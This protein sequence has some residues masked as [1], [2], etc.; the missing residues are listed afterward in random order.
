MCSSVFVLITVSVE[1]DM[2]GCIN[3]KLYADTTILKGAVTHRSEQDFRGQILSIF[4]NFRSKFE[5]ARLNEKKC[6]SGFSWI[7][8]NTST[9]NVSGVT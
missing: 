3:N 1:S 7:F 8:S 4:L 6:L 9:V 2:F 5:I